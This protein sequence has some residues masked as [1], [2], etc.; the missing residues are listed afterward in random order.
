[1]PE[2]IIS[3]A[4]YTTVLVALLI[5]TLV[6]VSAS[7]LDLGGPSGHVAFGLAIAILKASLVVL[8]FM[9]VLHSDRLTWTVVAVAVFWLGFFLSMTLTDYF[10]RGLFGYPGH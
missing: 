6:T 9:H 4:T 8:F 7:F 5:L 1:M 3:P 2:R 10:T